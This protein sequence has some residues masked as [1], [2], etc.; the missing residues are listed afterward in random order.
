MRKNRDIRLPKDLKGNLLVPHVVSQNERHEVLAPVSSVRI[1][2]TD[3]DLVQQR[4]CVDYPRWVAVFVGR[5][6]KE[7]KR[8]LD[9][10]MAPVLQ[11]CVPYKAKN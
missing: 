2:E 6:E 3:K 10:Y 7:C 5:T 11:L 1:G 9:K 4:Q 8:W